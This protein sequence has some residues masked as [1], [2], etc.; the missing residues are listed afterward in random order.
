MNSFR[1][2][3]LETDRIIAF[4]YAQGRG[5]RLFQLVKEA[6]KMMYSDKSN[7]YLETGRDRKS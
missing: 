2:T 3:V 6:E 1:K 7:Y 4:G 5:D